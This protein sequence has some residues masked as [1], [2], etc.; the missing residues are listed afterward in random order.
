MS[1]AKVE[2]TPSGD[3]GDDNEQIPVA[4]D[5][6]PIELEFLMK[7]FGFAGDDRQHLEAARITKDEGRDAASSATDETVENES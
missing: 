2:P 7:G 5:P 1:D 3:D 4:E 6:G